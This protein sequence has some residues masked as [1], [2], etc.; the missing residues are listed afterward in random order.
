MDAADLEFA[1]EPEPGSEGEYYPALAGRFDALIVDEGQDVSADWWLSLQILLTDPDRSPLYVFF[2][3]N[4][5]LFPVPTGL[6]FLEAPVQLTA[7]RD[8]PDRRP[9]GAKSDP[10]LLDLPLQGTGADGGRVVRARRR[11][12]A[13]SVRGALAAERFLS[14]FV[15]R[16]AAHR[17]GV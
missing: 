1:E 10:P 4:Q 7:R 15:P 8:P 14:L 13:G 17:L 5:K 16:S 11:A 12:G 6:P 3:D 2:D 9:L